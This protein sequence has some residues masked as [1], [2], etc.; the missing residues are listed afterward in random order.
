MFQIHR[1]EREFAKVII[2]LLKPKVT[3]SLPDG[4]QNIDDVNSAIKWMKERAAESHFLVV[5]QLKGKAVVGF[6]FLHES[7]RE[8]EIIDLHLGYLLG[9]IFWGAGLWQR[10][11]CRTGKVEW[12][13]R[14][15]QV[16]SG[17][18]LKLIM[19]LQ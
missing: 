19:W 4:W 14:T 6:V 7:N 3:R 10:T 12:H 5:Q 17:E 13:L 1:S 16:N 11:D 15:G 2:N 9:E 8:G 18:A